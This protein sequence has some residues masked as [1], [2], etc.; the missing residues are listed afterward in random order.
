MKIKALSLL[1]LTTFALS[2]CVSTTG[3][4]NATP[5]VYSTTQGGQTVNIDVSELGG[6]QGAFNNALS[7]AVGELKKPT[8]LTNITN[9]TTE[10]KTVQGKEYAMLSFTPP[11]VR[12]ISGVPIL[13]T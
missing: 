6:L 2:A 7:Q 13:P 11:M 1:A 8:V 5:N 12:C 10:R 4:N 3:T 9:F